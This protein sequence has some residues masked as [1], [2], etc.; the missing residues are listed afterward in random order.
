M[1]HT[2]GLFTK[3]QKG[4]LFANMR[5]KIAEDY[6]PGNPNHPE[7]L[8]QS[9]NAPRSETDRHGAESNPILGDPGFGQIGRWQ[10]VQ[11]DAMEN[12]IDQMIE[13]Y[14]RDRSWYA[15]VR[16]REALWNMYRRIEWWVMQQ[17]P[18]DKTQYQ[19][20][21]QMIKDCIYK[22]LENAQHTEGSHLGVSLPTCPA[23]YYHHFSGNYFNHFDA[24]VYEIP[25]FS[26]K[27]DV[28]LSDKFPDFFRY[29]SS[30]EDQEW[31]TV[32]SVGKD[33]QSGAEM[34][35][36]LDLNTLQIGNSSKITFNWRVKR[37]GQVR[38]KYLASAQRGNGILFYI[39]GQQVG[40]EWCE[41][42][43]WQQ[44]AFTLQPGQMYKFDW[45]IRKMRPE[46]WGQNAIYVKDIEV[47]E[48]VDTRKPPAP[49]DYDLDG[50]HVF[51]PD[52]WV[53]RSSE[54]I[55]QANFK[56]II[57]N[58]GNRTKRMSM[59]LENECEGDLSFAYKIGID[60]KPVDN[61]DHDIFFDDRFISK[62]EHGYGDYGSFAQSRHGIAWTVDGEKSETK[63]D[64][65]QITYDIVVGEN[66]KVDLSGTV[67]VECPPREIDHYEPYHLGIGMN[68]YGW[69]MSGNPDWK[70]NGSYL[71]IDEPEEGI[72]SAETT[73]YL[74]DD[75][76]F[77]FSFEHDLRPT[78]SFEVSVNGEGVHYSKGDRSG[79]QIKIALEAGYNAISF[80][81][82]DTLTEVPFSYD[83]DRPFSYGNGSSG[84]TYRIKSPMGSTVDV[85]RNWNV[86]DG[87]AITTSNGKTVTYDMKLN[88]ES[89][90]VLRE[91]MRI[92]P[93]MDSGYNPVTGV[94]RDN[95]V[96]EELF[97]EEDV[98]DPALS[99]NGNWEWHKMVSGDGVMKAQGHGQEHAANFYASMNKPGYICWQ[100]GGKFDPG[101]ALELQIDGVTVWTGNKSGGM[102]GTNEMYP[103]PPGGHE[104]RWVYK[105]GTKYIP[106][107][108]GNT[109]GSEES[110]NGTGGS[111]DD[112][113]GE[114]CY[115][116]GSETHS[117][118]YDQTRYE[119]DSLRTSSWNWD[120]HGGQIYSSNGVSVGHG[121]EA[122][123]GVIT[124]K[125]YAPYF[126]EVNYTEKLKV[127]PIKYPKVDNLRSFNTS[128]MMADEKRYTKLLT[129]EKN[130]YG[131]PVT[132]LS[133][134]SSK[135]DDDETVKPEELG[136]KYTRKIFDK[137]YTTGKFEMSFNYYSYLKDDH[138]RARLRIWLVKD[139]DRSTFDMLDNIRLN[140]GG[141]YKKNYLE[142]EDSDWTTSKKWSIKKSLSPGWWWVYIGITDTYSD[143]DRDKKKFPYYVAIKNLSIK[144][145]DPNS[146]NNY[147]LDK[148]R[149]DTETFVTVKLTNLTTG[150]V[151]YTQKLYGSGGN[152]AE[153][154]INLNNYITPGHAYSVSYTLNKGVGVA[155]GA[156]G[157]DSG[158]FTLSGGKFNEYWDAYC[159]DANGNVYREGDSPHP[160]DGW[161]TDPLPDR[162]AADGGSH[163]WLDVIRLYENRYDPCNGTRIVIEVYE[164]GALISRRFVTSTDDEYVE[165]P[166][167]NRTD[168]VQ[169]YKIVVK[170]EQGCSGDGAMLWGGS[171][172]MH[173]EKPIPRSWAKVTHF[174]VWDNK[175]IWMG[176]CYGSSIRVQVVREDGQSVFDQMYYG[177]G[178]RSFS[179]NQLPPSPYTKYSVIITT[180][181]LGT[182][183][184]WT[185]KEYYTTFRVHD[186]KAYEWYKF[187]PKPFDAQ[188]DFFMDGQLIKTFTE[189]GGYFTYSYSVP[190]GKHEFKWV[191][192]TYQEIGERC[193]EYAQLDWL[194]LTNW[195][196]DDV[197]VTPY[198]EGGGGDKCVEALIKCLLEI[199]RN[200]PKMC[201]IG[202]RIWLF[203]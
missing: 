25:L 76:W 138:Q 194:E 68:K 114:Q 180:N 110:N 163:A 116:S 193:W 74:P 79:T 182:V 184:S 101:E 96:F 94:T 83:F 54:S 134:L 60:E 119:S 31:V 29:V 154:M 152:L 12:A 170:F 66:S 77:I 20:V 185:G 122:D 125:F 118:N 159:T 157:L 95:M 175:P 155:A 141:N 91:H 55:T 93:A 113:W 28:P 50:E 146:E 67:E 26:M 172:F 9:P 129:K 27:K 87:G 32:H 61:I 14:L 22:I 177:D 171:L 106:E 148:P 34:I 121:S 58:D 40:G 90:V 142:L 176:G 108:S 117:I 150:R 151:E 127:Y 169:N 2:F 191:F 53:V 165:V 19:R 3:S 199:F 183:S 124:R 133:P 203:T 75:G 36:K 181:Q 153:Y 16:C 85:T 30:T 135:A 82:R 46:Q 104:F 35:L 107:V 143:S 144:I 128:S 43:E 86:T 5:A 51:L 47:V 179:V 145:S 38:F 89:E 168:K 11:L 81:I 139:S 57:I 105:D 109:G 196:C 21:L 158:A 70:D 123:G 136:T 201:V 7:H 15:S 132:A 137:V 44:A 167:R 161:W 71:K 97:N 160:N 84:S 164:E 4:V 88:P 190:K 78:E 49:L 131:M 13:Q 111:G 99:F 73:M 112:P 69:S 92:F 65:A 100:Y 130:Y 186:F 8:P 98:Y 59:E 33:E 24:A 37:Y 195:I 198:C 166:V 45:L 48:I 52:N 23:P 200:R 178:Y 115:P 162:D 187:I 10:T 1:G 140:Q 63:A 189:A 42:K 156:S 6:N 192:T 102:A 120:I 197:L 18:P 62:K 41:N 17:Q 188:L 174:E 173:D 202:K 126:G 147:L 56:G 39:N 64:H 80:Q 72:S 149:V 103:L